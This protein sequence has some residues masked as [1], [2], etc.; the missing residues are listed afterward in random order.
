MTYGPIATV[1]AGVVQAT[2]ETIPWAVDMTIAISGISGS[3]VAS[4]STTLKD[5][6]TNQT[7]TLADS[8][9][10]AT[11]VVTQV[12]R[13]SALNVGHTYALIISFTAKAGSPAT[14]LST[15]TTITVPA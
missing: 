13:G 7:V 6:T 8:P 1:P 5:T 9:S 3:S 12:I 4:P 10:A 14:V 15:I 11:N 2:S